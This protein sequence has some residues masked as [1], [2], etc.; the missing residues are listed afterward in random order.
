ML[1]GDKQRVGVKN[2]PGGSDDEDLVAGEGCQRAHEIDRTTLS[3]SRQREYTLACDCLYVIT[4]IIFS[5][6]KH[7]SIRMS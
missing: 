2:S 1:R 6:S 5:I 3:N 4:I 7:T